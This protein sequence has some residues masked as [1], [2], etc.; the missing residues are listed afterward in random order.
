MK[1]GLSQAQNGPVT[2]AGPVRGCLGALL[3]STGTS[4]HREMIGPKSDIGCGGRRCTGTVDQAV[5]GF[6][7][8]GQYPYFLSAR[9]HRGAFLAT[10]AAS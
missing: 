4:F 9:I 1:K 7:V 3:T 2:H 8:S 6:A 10:M 5:A